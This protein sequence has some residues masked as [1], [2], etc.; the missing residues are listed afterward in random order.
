MLEML[1][2][3][4]SIKTCMILILGKILAFKYGNLV[5]LDKECANKGLGFYLI[6]SNKYY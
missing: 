5:L 1:K 4:L 6:L 2:I 3:T